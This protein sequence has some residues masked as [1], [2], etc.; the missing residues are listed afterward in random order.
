M[1]RLTVNIIVGKILIRLV[2]A[3]CVGLFY[4]FS[5]VAGG[6]VLGPIFAWVFLYGLFLFELCVAVLQAC[7]F[8]GLLVAYIQEVAFKPRYG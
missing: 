1:C 8:V 3:T 4:P 5:W 6:S 7:I 2:S